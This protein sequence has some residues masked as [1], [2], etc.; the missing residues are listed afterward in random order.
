MKRKIITIITAIT[1]DRVIVGAEELYH[2]L[3]HFI[4]PADIF[5]ELLERI[6]K[7]P[8]EIFIDNERF[9]HE[10]RMFYRLEDGRYILV[11]VKK[12]TEGAFFASMYSTGKTI[13]SK[14]KKMKRLKI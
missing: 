1:G 13:R 5:L 9:P 6:L 12:T 11:V 8:T 7:D 10:Y 4:I 2:A 14:H 3:R